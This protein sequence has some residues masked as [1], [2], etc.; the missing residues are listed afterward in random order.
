[1]SYLYLLTWEETNL[2]KNNFILHSIKTKFNVRI[3]NFFTW[4]LYIILYDDVVGE[5]MR[6]LPTI[7]LCLE[8]SGLAYD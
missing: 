8:E 4:I 6:I 7:F 2:L 1:M 5:I 3:K